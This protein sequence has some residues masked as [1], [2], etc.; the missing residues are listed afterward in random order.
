MRTGLA[1]IIGIRIAEGI[2]ES[3]GSPPVQTYFI[4]SEA[5]EI[6]ETEASVT[7]R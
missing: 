7:W 1:I 5:D 6:L 2:V 4:I 3:S